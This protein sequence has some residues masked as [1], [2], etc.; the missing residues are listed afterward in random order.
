[1]ASLF[2]L[3]LGVRHVAAGY[4]RNRFAT[5]QIIG[6]VMAI[7]IAAAANPTTGQAPAPATGS[8]PGTGGSTVLPANSEDAAYGSTQPPNDN[9]LIFEQFAQTGLFR[10]LGKEV[11]G[12]LGEK[13]GMVVDVLFDRAGQPRA[14]I[15]D[16]G[17]FLGVGT[18][19]IA[20]D[21]RTLRFETADQKETIVAALDR[22]QIKAAPEYKGSHQ[23]VAIVTPAKPEANDSGW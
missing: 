16:F 2:D 7:S 3:W 10:I 13:M 20:I 14:A 8:P 19:K 22:D 6:G 15:I 12:A 1:M 5:L 21:W 9:G 17:G 18:R 11:R 4:R 23:I